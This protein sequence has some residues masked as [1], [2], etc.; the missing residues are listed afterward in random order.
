M[1]ETAAALIFTSPA[2]LTLTTRTQASRTTH[3]GREGGPGGLADGSREASCWQ[4]IVL[5]RAAIRTPELNPTLAAVLRRAK[6]QACR[7][8]ASRAR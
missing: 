5:A 2:I 7:R 1:F 4:D 6:S 8:G 3:F